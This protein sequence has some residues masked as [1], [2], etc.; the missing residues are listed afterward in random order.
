M[1]ERMK[2][3]ENWR[4]MHRAFSVQAMALAAAIQGTWPMIP[5]DLKA[6][7]PTSIVHWV[8]V[9]LLAAGIVGR[10]VDQGGITEAKQ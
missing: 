6:A 8:S 9:A 1:G 2:L 3:V 5:E 4:R 10:L 7:L